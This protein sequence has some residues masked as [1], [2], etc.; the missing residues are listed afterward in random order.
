MLDDLRNS[1]SQS[2]IEDMAANEPVGDIADGHFL[3]MTAPQR[4]LVS[5]LLLVMTCAMG[6]L[7]LI[8]FNKV[9]I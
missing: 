8:A 9:G 7:L 2:F 4:F 1:A 5:V 3:G 6:T